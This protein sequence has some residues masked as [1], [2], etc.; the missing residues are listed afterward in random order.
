MSAYFEGADE[1]VFDFSG[2]SENLV[3]LIDSDL[4]GESP[5]FGAQALNDVFTFNLGSKTLKDIQIFSSDGQQSK[6]LMFG[7]G[8]SVVKIESFYTDGYAGNGSVGS[9]NQSFVFTSDVSETETYGYSEL[10]QL[11]GDSYTEFLKTEQGSQ[12]DEGTSYYAIA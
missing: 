1:F 3:K 5:D 2:T 12:F 8:E 9:A 7:I 10:D 11:F 6:D 4:T